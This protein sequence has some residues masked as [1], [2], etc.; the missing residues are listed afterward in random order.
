MKIA[1]DPRPK[2]ELNR[3][4]DVFFVH[5]LHHGVEAHHH[6]RALEPQVIAGRVVNPAHDVAGAKHD[7]LGVWMLP[8]EALGQHVELDQVAHAT[9]VLSAEEGCVLGEELRVVGLRAVHVGPREHHQLRDFV[10]RHVI[11]QLLEGDDVPGV[12]LALA[13]PGVVKDTEVHDRA[14]V[15]AAEDVFHLLAPHV[16][17]VMDDVFGAI[18]ERTPV[19]PHDP[20]GAVELPR[21]ELAKAPADAGDQH[22]ALG[23]RR[24]ALARRRPWLRRLRGLL[25]LLDLFAWDGSRART[26]HGPPAPSRTDVPEQARAP[27]ARSAC[28]GL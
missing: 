24:G 12:P 17:L 8:K 5:D 3:P 11:E 6:D 26:R 1:A 13:P 16:D 21:E 4:H 15:P 10:L 18:G 23:S 27:C 19:Y 2:R 14:D 28:D 7:G 20:I 9:E 22:C 25:D